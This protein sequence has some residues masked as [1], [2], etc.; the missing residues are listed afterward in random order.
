MKAKGYFFAILSAVSYGLIPLFAIPLKSVDMS[1]DTVLF[2]RFFLGAAMIGLYLIATRTDLRVSGKELL[3]L[4]LLGLMFALSSTCLF[5][6]YDYLSAGVAS[7]ILFMYPVFVALIMAVFFREKLSWT[8]GVAII[9]ATGGVGML[10]M[11]EDSFEINVPGLIIVLLSALFY[12]LYIVLVNQSKV[13]K[14][15]GAKITFY[16]M[17][18][19]SMFFLIKSLAGGNSLAI[20]SLSSAGLI[21]LFAFVTTTISCITLVYAIQYIGSTP[22]SI[23]GALEPVVAVCV[24]VVLFH[25]AFTTNLL[26]GIVLIIVAV[27]LNILSEPI[28]KALRIRAKKIK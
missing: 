7:T 23:L 5:L 26:L 4:M 14:M 2:Y 19:C 22:T 17:F 25:E 1:F 28:Q 20:P 12:A 13:K 10:S 24:S 18:F 15:S 21:T 6:G 3:S 27:I 16:S 9:L 8:T 11:K